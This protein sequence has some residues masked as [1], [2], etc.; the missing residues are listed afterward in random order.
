MKQLSR[1]PGI[2]RPLYAHELDQ[3]YISWW[4]LQ[5]SA[6]QQD[7][8]LRL[9]QLFYLNGSQTLRGHRASGDRVNVDVYEV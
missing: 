1:G 5:T 4:K 9:F 3:V 8:V 7:S 2:T 6:S